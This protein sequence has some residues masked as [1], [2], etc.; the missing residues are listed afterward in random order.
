MWS[1]L[2]NWYNVE[3]RK[4]DPF[5]VYLLKR[6]KAPRFHGFELIESREYQ[7]GDF[8]ELPVL[9]CPV[10]MKLSMELNMLGKLSKFFF[11]I[12][13]TTMEL[14][15]DAGYQHFRIIP[16]TLSNGLFINF[17]PVSLQD[18]YFLMNE[19]QARGRIYG[20]KITGEGLPFYK[21]T[22]H[23]EFYKI[24]DIQINQIQLPK[25]SLIE[26]RSSS[27]LY[28]IEGLHVYP[29][30]PSEATSNTTPSFLIVRGW[31]VDV[32]AKD[33]A[34]GVYLDID[35]Q[36]YPTYYGFLREDIATNYNTPAYRYSGFQVGIPVSK[37]GK[38]SHSLSIKILT[39]DKKA[40]YISRENV[41]FEIAN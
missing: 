28:E 31:V 32:R 40:Y 4:N 24:P 5:P 36:L 18:V 22:M 33:I 14:L 7:T 12:P 15:G 25:F 21:H 16:D 39:N 23:V 41:S 29:A 13:V 34:G 10:L 26:P 1:S 11:R 9:N 38:G 20:I 8:I 17:L 27:T 30:K 37:I 19:H 6:R 3:K 35:G 2:Y